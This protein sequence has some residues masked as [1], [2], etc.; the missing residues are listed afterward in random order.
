MEQHI[1]TFINKACL[2]ERHWGAAHLA[3]IILKPHS[4]VPA[5]LPVIM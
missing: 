3:D 2:V 5:E 1:S 4:L